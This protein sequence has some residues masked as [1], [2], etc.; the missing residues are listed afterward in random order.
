[1]L[2]FLLLQRHLFQKQILTPLN[3]PPFITMRPVTVSDVARLAPD[4][5]TR[6]LF[7]LDRRMLTI[8]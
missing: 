4:D 2:Q 6:H 3:Q 7:L 8:R 5:W 1:M